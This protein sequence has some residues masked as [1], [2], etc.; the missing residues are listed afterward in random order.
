MYPSG[1]LDTSN[2]NWL[3]LTKQ[4]SYWV[5]CRIVGR[6]GE[7]GW[8]LS[9]LEQYPTPSL[10]T[11]LTRKCHLFWALDNKWLLCQGLKFIATAGPAITAAL[12]VSGT[13]LPPLLPPVK[14]VSLPS[15][16]FAS[17]VSD[18]AS[19]AGLSSWQSPGH[20]PFLQ[21][22]GKLAK[23]VFSFFSHVGG[24]AILPC[25]IW[26]HK[27]VNSSNRMKFRQWIAKWKK[28]VLRVSCC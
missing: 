5:A 27:L 26:T 2:R 28:N 21:L 18:S 22:Q 20:M 11:G 15:S 6:T 1:F 7:L 24:E 8:R 17:P 3:W 13:R 14:G 10:R 4:K 23:Q 19:H 9:F 12:S 25:L 16:P